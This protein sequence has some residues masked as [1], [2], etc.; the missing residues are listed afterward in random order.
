MP[1]IS[2]EEFYSLVDEG[3]VR[4]IHPIRVMEVLFIEEICTLQD[5]L[6][7]AGVSHGTIRNMAKKS[8]YHTLK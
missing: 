3:K 5:I 2:K 4:S 7:I 6:L 8:G 1:S